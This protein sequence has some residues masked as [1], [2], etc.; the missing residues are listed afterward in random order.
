[1]AHPKQKI[2]FLCTGNSARS[3]FAEYLTNK[4]GRGRFEAYSAGS[5]PSGKV[6]PFTLK[7][8]NDTT[9]STWNAVLGT[10]AKT[11]TL[12]LRETQLAAQ[13]LGISLQ[14]VQVS[15]PDDFHPAFAAIARDRAEALI[16][17]P[18]LLFNQH[19]NKLIDLAAK[20]GLPTVY[21]AREF[22]DAGGLMS[23][24]SSFAGQ[25]RRAAVYVDKILKG[26]KPADLPVEQPTKFQLVINLKTAK[27]LGLTIPQSVLFRADQVIQ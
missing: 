14:A 19:A 25:F 9:N 3:I 6:N 23:Y 27:A 10:A 1:M 17:V 12:A 11:A 20:S 21:Y 15:G 26:A 13:S 24:A 4:I 18:D 7:V 16:V 8:E 22:V 5:Q 2:L